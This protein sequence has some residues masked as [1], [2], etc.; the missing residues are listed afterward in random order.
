[1]TMMYILMLMEGT[2]VTLH[3]LILVLDSLVAYIDNTWENVSVWSMY[4]AQV[5]F[6]AH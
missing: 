2:H 5:T 6:Q 1:M 4:N 3:I